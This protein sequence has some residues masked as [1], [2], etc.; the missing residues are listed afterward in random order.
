VKVRIRK[1]EAR[2]K[3]IRELFGTDV[4]VWCDV[5]SEEVR[6]VGVE[7]LENKKKVEAY[8]VEDQKSVADARPGY[9]G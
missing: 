1:V 9:L 2:M 7:V 8:D 6:F 4:R 3:K 5:T